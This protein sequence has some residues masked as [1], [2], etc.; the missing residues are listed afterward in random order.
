MAANSLQ[1]P[2]FPSGKATFTVVGEQLAAEDLNAIKSLHDVYN[3]EYER[4]VTAYHGR[5]QSRMLHEAKLKVNPP[6][7]KDIVLSYWRTEK[8]LPSQQ[9]G[10]K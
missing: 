3:A 2:A 9:G 4:L 8:E 5:E 1:I 7:P 6:K 10:G